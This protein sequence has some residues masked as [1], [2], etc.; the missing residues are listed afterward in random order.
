MPVVIKSEKVNVNFN[1]TLCAY[2]LHSAY[3]Y[4]DK[5]GIIIYHTCLSTL[6]SWSSTMTMI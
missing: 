4:L 2:S 1:S 6:H 5:L 3:R